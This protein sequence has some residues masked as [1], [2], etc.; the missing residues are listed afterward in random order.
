M[1]AA[2]AAIF[3]ETVLL[4]SAGRQAV[5]LLLRRPALAILERSE[6]IAVRDAAGE[7]HIAPTF[8][9]DPQ[10]LRAQVMA[11][12]TQVRKLREGIADA[13]R[14]D[15]H[16]HALWARTRALAHPP[17][18]PRE[19]ELPP[20]HQTR[21]WR[22]EANLRAMRL[23][24]AKEPGELTTD[25]LRIL[26]PI[27]GLGR[28]VDRARAEAAA[29][30]A[31]TGAVRPRPRVLHT[32]PHHRVARRTAVPVPSRARRQRRRRASPGAQRRHRPPDLRFQ[33]APL[34]RARGRRPDQEAG[35][36]R[37]RIFKSQRHAAARTSTRRRPLS[38]ALRAL[39]P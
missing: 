7:L 28:P 3:A 27:F 10:V 12:Q 23:V 13:T 8:K 18:A 5:P 1:A 26:A 14:F 32:A 36:D 2:F 6:L 20:D 17:A 39:G 37:R 15:R 19:L 25:D 38:Y 22:T 11:T 21:A 16:A 35:V 9:G 31:R 33:P 34:P 24:L 29:A 4:E 30:R